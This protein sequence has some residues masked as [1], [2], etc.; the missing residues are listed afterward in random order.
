MLGNALCSKNKLFQMPAKLL[1]I[2]VGPTAITWSLVDCDFNVLAWD[3]IIWRNKSLKYDIINS[4]NIL[5]LIFQSKRN[6]L[7]YLTLI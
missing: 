3:S 7:F 5:N 4:V 1:G 2:H 6:L